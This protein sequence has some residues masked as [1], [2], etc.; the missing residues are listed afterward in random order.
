MKR[1]QELESV[2]WGFFLGAAVVLA[3]LSYL[4]IRPLA[5]ADATLAEKILLVVVLDL[6]LAALLAWITNDQLHRR[7]LRKHGAKEK[8]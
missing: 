5:N 1:L 3:P 7:M 2:G 8:R 4:A 6:V